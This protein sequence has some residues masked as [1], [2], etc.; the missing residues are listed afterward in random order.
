MNARALPGT[1][2]F[3]RMREADVD[4]VMQIELAAYAFPWSV[5][6]FNDSIRSGY[7]CRVARDEQRRLVGYFLMLM[8]I[9]EAHLLNITVDPA[10]H[11]KGFGLALLEHV[12]ASARAH[13]MA[14]I[15][16]EVRPSNERALAMYERY[17]Y[18]RIGVRRKYYPAPN[19]TREDAIVMRMKL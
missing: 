11:G 12:E 18:K 10:L 13:D 19:D 8:I 3:A 15:L 4:D 6:N 1:L 5:G 2:K 14:S 17:G 7:F 16:L 9:D